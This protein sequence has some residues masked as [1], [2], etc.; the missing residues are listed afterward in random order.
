MEAMV[1][2]TTD[3]LRVKECLIVQ[4]PDKVCMCHL[5]HI[6]N[7]SLQMYQHICCGACRQ[8]WR[9]LSF[10]IKADVQNRHLYKCIDNMHRNCWPG[11]WIIA[12]MKTVNSQN[13]IKC[14]VTSMVLEGEYLEGCMGSFMKHQWAHEEKRST[15]QCLRSSKRDNGE[16]DLKVDLTS[17]VE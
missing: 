7:K 1:H 4:Q 9:K 3:W 8:K 17:N 2:I 15:H 12:N 11:H 6:S 13:K 10:R 14:K 5:W 16:W